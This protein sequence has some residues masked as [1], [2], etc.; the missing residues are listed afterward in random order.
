MTGKDIVMGAGVF[1]AINENTGVS[2][3]TQNSTM[4]GKLVKYQYINIY[5]FFK[6][7]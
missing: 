2:V 3:F 7:K 4:C 5:Y 1:Y 6:T